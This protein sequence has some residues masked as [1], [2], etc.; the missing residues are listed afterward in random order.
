MWGVPYERNSR[1]HSSFQ[2]H[3]LKGLCVPELVAH[4]CVPLRLGW[5]S[6]K[7]VAP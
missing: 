7:N 1:F 2:C 3:S 4:V 5:L 6:D